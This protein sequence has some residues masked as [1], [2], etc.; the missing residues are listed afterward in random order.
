MTVVKA[1]LRYTADH[2]WINSETPARVGVSDYAQNELGEVVY[3]E[4]PEVGDELTAG[5]YCGELESTKSVAE[6]EAP[7]SGTVVE[8]N[9]EVLDNP[10]L[11][12]EDPYGAGWLYTVTVTEEGPLSS[13]E[14]YAEE[15]GG[16]IE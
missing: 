2:D 7:V 1:G 13:A 12:N 10:E 15:V 9:Q 4:L 14:E 8:V 16:T 3:V 5:E 11:V 6:L